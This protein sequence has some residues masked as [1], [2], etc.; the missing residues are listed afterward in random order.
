MS[1]L[2]VPEDVYN[3]SREEYLTSSR[4]KEI[5]W[6]TQCAPE[7]GYRSPASLDPSVLL[8]GRAVHKLTLEGRDAFLSHYAR[9]PL[10]A[11]HANES[12]PSAELLSQAERISASVWRDH[13]ASR[14]LS[15]GV[16]EAVIRSRYCGVPCQIRMD[17]FNPS[18]ALIVEL[19]TTTCL[20]RFQIECWELGYYWQLAFYR[21]VLAQDLHCDPVEISCR[22]IAVEQKPP[23]NVEVLQI[24]ATTLAIGQM[25]NEEVIRI[26]HRQGQTI[27]E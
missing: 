5:R 9:Q 25:E 7:N 14:L 15:E 22:I 16:P 26:W 19:K 13:S 27:S 11:S 24:P 17:W 10:S 4:L 2:Q 3:A 18:K 21:A 12:T 8:L 1:I 6:A 20:E 23:F